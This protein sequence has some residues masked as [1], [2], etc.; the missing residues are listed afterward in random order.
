MGRF[1]LRIHPYLTT[2]PNFHL[3]QLSPFSTFTYRLAYLSLD[4]MRLAA[5]F[6]ALLATVTVALLPVDAGPVTRSRGMI[7]L[8]IRRIERDNGDLHVELRHQQHINRAERLMARASGRPGPSDAQLRANME[9]RAS[10]LSPVAKRFNDTSCSSTLKNDECVQSF[11]RRS[12]LSLIPSSTSNESPVLA[13]NSSQI[14]PDGP[15]IQ[16]IATVQLGTPP[17]D[18]NISLDSGSGD[19]WVQSDVCKG[20]NGVDCGNHP[21]LGGSS[22]SFINTRK[23]FKV[24]YGSGNVSGVLVN[25]TL[26]LANM[27]LTNHTFGVAHFM[28][29]SFTQDSVA[30]GLMGLGKQAL[31]NQG[32]PTPVQA[33]HNARYIDAAIT[34]YRLPRSADHSNDGEVTF[35][36]LDETKFDPSTLVT[37]NA[38]TDDKGESFW[39]AALDGVS[40]DGEDVE[41]ASNVSLMDTGSTQLLVPPNDA[42]AIHAKIPGAFKQGDQYRVPCN[43][44]ARVALK[45]GG[46]SFALNLKDLTGSD[47]NASGDCGSGVSVFN[48]TKILAGGAFLKSVYFSTNEDDNTISL[49][50]PI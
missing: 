13:H 36:G 14:F 37:L 19:F 21:S 29:K 48:D 16:F 38:T 35:G 50:V 33:L 1:T 22:K 46:K 3:S 8:P 44:T 25:D 34:S 27:V 23:Q 5:H 4:N 15:D 40:V 2:F 12:P 30:A 43:T 7:T 6:F 42:A 9:R 45:F 47:G 20:E 18:F 24:G 28:S 10:Y 39:F 32:V 11:S 31:S 17:R 49:A 26:V 41:I